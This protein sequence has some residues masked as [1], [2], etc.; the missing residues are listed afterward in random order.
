MKK[1]YKIFK[2]LRIVLALSACLVFLTSSG[3]EFD[4]VAQIESKTE[5]LNVLRE[6][7]Q[8]YVQRDT[9]LIDEYLNLFSNDVVVISTGDRE[10]SNGKDQLKELTLWDWNYWL[11]LKV[12]L[13]RVKIKVDNDVAWFAIKGSSLYDNEEKAFDIR[14]TG[15]MVKKD[16]TTLIFKQICYSEPLK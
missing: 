15:S 6:F 8:Y 5:I 4:N 10:F 3:Q 11:D 14:L 16:S 7:Q 12:P 13:N 1:S 2:S 9:S